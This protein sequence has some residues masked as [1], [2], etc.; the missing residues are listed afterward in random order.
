MEGQKGCL[1]HLHSIKY[2][3]YYSAC[4]ALQLLQ[5]RKREV[6]FQ[7]LISLGSV[8]KFILLISHQV[9]HHY[10]DKTFQTYAVPETEAKD[11]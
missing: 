7:L 3:K 11:N 1:T 8:C 9:Q 10:T 4:G 2:G 6:L 5:T